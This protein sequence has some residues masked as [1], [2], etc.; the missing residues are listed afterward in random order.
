MEFSVQWIDRVTPEDFM[1]LPRSNILQH[2]AYAM[3]MGKRRGHKARTGL[4]FFNGEK[5]G[6][7]Q[8][9]EAGFL[10][11]IF[12]AVMLDRGPL[13][14]NGFGGAAHTKIFFQWFDETFPRRLGRK[15]RI[16]PEVIDS[17]VSAALLRQVG[18]ERLSDEKG[19]QTLWWDLSV[20]DDVARTAL[21][22]GWSSSLKQAEQATIEIQWDEG[23]RFYPWL[24]KHYVLDKAARGYGGISPQL[25]DN[26]AA[27]STPGFCTLIGKARAEGKDIAAILLF[28]HGQSA[29][30][31]IGWTSDKGREFCAHHLLLWQARNVLQDKG[32]R[33][34]DLGGINDD[35]GG[36]GIRK[37]KEGTGAEPVCYLGHY[38]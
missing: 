29:T 2:A 34:L 1:D 27:F 20:A 14:F 23:L 5:A 9:I 26:I 31:Q 33:H 7:F 30:Y 13:W 21:A 4:I 18:L 36:Q 19:Y 35:E 11:N 10:F 3:A 32:I 37:F 8:V 22:K 17:P 28:C 12:H 6:L 25:L 38:V 24:K 16:L 15:R